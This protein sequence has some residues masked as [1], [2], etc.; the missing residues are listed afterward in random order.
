MNTRAI[1]VLVLSA[2][3]S[4]NGY[5]EEAS[6][7]LGAFVTNKS[8]VYEGGGNKNSPYPFVDGYWGP[9]FIS[10]GQLG[11]FI[12]GNDHWGFALAAGLANLEDKSRGHSKQLAGMHKLEDVFVG[13]VQAFIE[14][15]YGQ[16]S[17]SY[18][19]DISHQ[20][21]GYS[22]NVGYRYSLE[23]GHWL[24]EPAFSATWINE[25]I[26]EY[27]YGVQ[28]NEVTSN[29]A[30]YQPGS[31]SYLKTELNLVYFFNRYH[32]V[33]LGVSYSQLSNEI[34]DSPIVNHTSTSSALVGYV[35]S[36]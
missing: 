15:H 24:I 11:S 34:T 23:V 13:S 14:T 30:A 18:E 29:R 26:S 12:A 25:S 36:F 8:S 1:P 2:M 33:A 3:C 22:A 4:A 9:F 19:K 21:N 32:A 7:S 27:Y 28:H 5:C 31:A 35:Y 20:H 16:L 17:A 6:L 10:N